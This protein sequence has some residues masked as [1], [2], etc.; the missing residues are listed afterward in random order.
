MKFSLFIPLLLQGRIHH[1]QLTV[2]LCL[3]VRG[4]GI[5]ESRSA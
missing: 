1:R 4:P 2:P 5:A 3:G